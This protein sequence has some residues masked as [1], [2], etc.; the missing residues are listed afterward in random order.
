M[1][2]ASPLSTLSALIS[3]QVAILEDVYAER[4]TPL[5]SLDEP[6]AP[7]PLDFDP[8]LAS[9]KALIVAAAAQLM[10][11]V[12]PPV[13][14][15][16]EYTPGMYFSATIGFVVDVN[17]PDIMA[18]TGAQG[19][20]VKDLSTQTGVE[21]SYIGVYR[22]VFLSH[23]DMLMPRILRFLATRH[24][25]REVS[26]DVFTNNRIS[27]L[28]CKNKSL[29]EIKADP[30]SRLDEAPMAGFVSF[31]TD[32]AFLS[33][34]RISEFL[35]NPDK[36]STPFNLA[37]KTDRKLWEWYEE[38]GNEF[39]NRRFTYGMAKA[40]E[41]HFPP[42]MFIEGLKLK[43]LKDGDVVVDVG[44]NVGSCTLHLYKAF[45]NLNYVVQDLDQPIVQAAKFWNENAPEAI[46]SG[47]VKLEVNNFFTP[48][49]V[50]G[51]AVYFLRVVIH[52]WSDD[53]AKKI[54]KQLRDAASD[55]SKLV[56]F[57]T[58]AQCLS[59]PSIG[60]DLRL[61][62]SIRNNILPNLRSLETRTLC[63]FPLP[64][65]WSTITS[66][67]IEA[68][69][70]EY[71][72]LEEKFARM[73]TLLRICQSLQTL[74][75]DFEYPEY[76]TVI[77]FHGA[78]S[79]L[80][81][82]ILAHVR[83]VAISKQATPI[84]TGLRLPRLSEILTEIE[85]EKDLCTLITCSQATPVVSEL[86][87]PKRR[88]RTMDNPDVHFRALL[89]ILSSLAVLDVTTYVLESTILHDIGT[90][91]LLP[92][93]YELKANI[94]C[95]SD[96]VRML[97]RVEDRDGTLRI[98]HGWVPKNTNLGGNDI[99]DFYDRLWRLSVSRC[100]NFRLMGV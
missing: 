24:I 92:H 87:Y 26:P 45:P 17:I 16:M 62:Q 57:D 54:L 79:S 46:R 90:G 38:P 98:G 94:A 32:E 72:V 34:T 80:Q 100:G 15:L 40:A 96:F 36:A 53:Y 49:P 84:I 51:A 12:R 99:L 4:S 43:G 76:P 9:T 61:R 65:P 19:I 52:D 25:F 83:K 1:T 50:K 23:V 70:D 7:N 93:L 44:G 30:L 48:Q 82:V 5:P 77:D 14:T 13:E 69:Y 20:H 85:T 59:L 58:V 35:Q 3:T 42:D 28:L 29:K 74:T 67:K 6:F 55:S 56:L 75:L 39:R 86:H 95:P 37:L 97:E 33:S 47:A 88:F 89:H 41:T 60:D 71:V 64:L 10:A 73:M 91:E 31:Y 68:H 8:S 78:L 2:N 66:L 81:P 63:I 22:L 11:I 27:S 18:E 21:A